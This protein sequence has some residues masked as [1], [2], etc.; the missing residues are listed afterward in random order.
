M[1]V[2][3]FFVFSLLVLSTSFVFAQS[4]DQKQN[5]A[6]IKAAEEGKVE[7]L[8]KILKNK[9]DI[10]FRDENGG[11]ALFYA[12]QNHHLDIVKILL[13][14]GA[15][16]DLSLYDGFSP[17][18]SACM[19][20]D[21]DIAEYLAHSGA[22]LNESDEYSATA[23]H[24]AVGMSDYY[25]TDMLLFYGADA[26]KLTYQKTSPLLV[27]ALNS[28]T[29]IA[30]LLLKKDAN[31]N[32]ANDASFSPLSV[33]IQNNDT[34]L[35]D[36]LMEYGA[37]PELMN[38]SPFKPYAWA[39]ANHNE[40]AFKKLKPKQAGTEA[41]RNR[42]TNPLNIAYANNNLPL[43]KDLKKQGYSSGFLPF[44]N[45]V[46]TQAS[47]SFNNQDLFFNFGFGIQDVK[48]KTIIWLT[49]GTRF[50]EKAVLIKN[51]DIDFTQVWEHRRYFEFALQKYFVIPLNQNE[52]RPFF[53]LG[54][55]L[56]MGHYDGLHQQINQAFVLVPQMGIQMDMKAVFFSVSYEYTHYHLYNISP[57]KIKLSFGYR[58][59]FTPKPKSFQLLWL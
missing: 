56:M 1:M 46:L 54:A 4:T 58:I 11:T 52:I 23:L 13:Y 35:F 47:I 3:K 21:F 22:T 20:G 41:F 29:A 42:R 24:Y 50:K 53:G 25:I 40:Y 8:I 19:S 18:M 28:D 5:F 2:H 34:A 12:T 15:D 30:R 36:L 49:Y 17:L 39:L 37:K 38:K 14:N 45:A 31:P 43:A 16:P 48:Y 7:T 33:A 57:H 44:Y 51:S 9:P 26:N 6:L 32:Q 27:A 10:D 59:N 55:Q